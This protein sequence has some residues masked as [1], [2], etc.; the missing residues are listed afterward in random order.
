[1][2]V[3]KGENSH[4][5][6][7]ESNGYRLVFRETEQQYK[8]QP[9][10]HRFGVSSYDSKGEYARIGIGIAEQNTSV[11]FQNAVEMQMAKLDECRLKIIK[12]GEEL[13]RKLTAIDE[14]LAALPKVFVND[15]ITDNG[16]EASKK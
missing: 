14:F 7:F 15:G 6:T 13:R 4:S 11:S 16:I 5:F 9:Y 2:K 3:V 10:S 12:E 1:M 8:Q